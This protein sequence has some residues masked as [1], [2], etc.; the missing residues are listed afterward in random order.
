[1]LQ[2][3]KY[4]FSARYCVCVPLV[5]PCIMKRHGHLKYCVPLTLRHFS[6]LSCLNYVRRGQPYVSK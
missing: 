3:N 6:L 2:R 1:M 5:Y 4:L